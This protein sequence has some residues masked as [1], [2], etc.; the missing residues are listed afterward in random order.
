MTWIDFPRHG[1]DRRSSVKDEG[2]A[3]FDQ[4]RSQ[5]CNMALLIPE[6]DCLGRVV[7]GGRHRDGSAIDAFEHTFTFQCAQIAPDARF[8]GVQLTAEGLHVEEV[9]GFKHL[10]DSELALCCFH[11][12]EHVDGACDIASFDDDVF[13]IDRTRL[14]NLDR[15][16]HGAQAADPPQRALEPGCSHRP[17]GMRPVPFCTE[18]CPRYLLGHPIQPH[19]AMQSLGFASGP[20]SMVAG[21]LYCCECNLCTM[22]ACPDDLDPKSISVQMKPGA[23]ERGLV[24]EG[25]LESV[26]A[27]PMAEFRRVPMWRLMARNTVV[28]IKNFH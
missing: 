10:A 20:D 12:F 22:F 11:R 5:H 18:F 15:L 19:R 13:H 2:L 7:A 17:F 4:A 27:H 8:G 28:L 6:P 25:S 21:T 1:G 3:I 16:H 9:A 26:T 24:F 14:S 23:R